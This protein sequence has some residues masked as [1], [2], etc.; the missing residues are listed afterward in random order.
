M[1]LGLLLSLIGLILTVD[2]GSVKETRMEMQL[3]TE[4]AGHL[5]LNE[6]IIY[7]MTL[8][9]DVSTKKQLFI[10]ADGVTPDPAD[11]PMLT[12]SNGENY[13]TCFQTYQSDICALEG[14]LL[15]PNMKISII[16][17]C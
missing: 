1:K 9:D 5:G 2:D 15:A 3:N 4:V 11:T 17:E 14:G 12:V 10:V 8:P 13:M 7:E 16:A 6:R